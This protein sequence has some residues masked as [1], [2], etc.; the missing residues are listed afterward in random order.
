MFAALAFCLGDPSSNTP[1]DSTSSSDASALL[2]PDD[3]LL[4]VSKSGSESGWSD[5]SDEA[6]PTSACGVALAVALVLLRGR[7]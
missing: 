5:A 6:E 3:A 7:L 4:R 2:T 1:S